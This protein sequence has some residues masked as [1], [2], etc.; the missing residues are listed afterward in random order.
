MAKNKGF[1]DMFLRRNGSDR[2]Q[3]RYTALASSH[4]DQVTHVNGRYRSSLLWFS[5]LIKNIM[6]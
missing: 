3:A 2:V 4:S 5:I 1:L 6:L